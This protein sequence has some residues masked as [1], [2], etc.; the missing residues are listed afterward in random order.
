[1]RLPVIDLGLVGVARVSQRHQ[2]M[3]AAKQRH[4]FASASVAKADRRIAAHW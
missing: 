2:L 3:S 1:M 4:S